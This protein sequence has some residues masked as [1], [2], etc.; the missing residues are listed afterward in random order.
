MKLLYKFASRSRPEKFLKC[1]ENIFSLAR[2]DDFVI[3]CSFDI[4][5]PTMNCPEMQDKLYGYGDKIIACYGLSEN[6]VDAIN[7][8]FKFANDWDILINMSDDMVFLQE[9]YDTEIINDFGDNLDEFIHYPD[10][11]QTDV[12][13]MSIM[14]KEYYDRFGYVYHPD[15]ISLWCDKEAT[16]VAQKTG[17]YK[18]IRKQI[19]EHNHPVWGK[20]QYDDQ[21]RHTEKFYN[22]DRITFL[23]RKSRNFDL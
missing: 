8:D 11:T 21:Y 3:L 9:G 1:L 4:D 19:L 15:Y 6:K 14:G 18:L 5:D 22:T 16:E 20:S 2:H 17:K 13:T 10:G 23:K 7:R 12:S